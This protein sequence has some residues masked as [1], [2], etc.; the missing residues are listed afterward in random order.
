M[1]VILDARWMNVRGKH[2]GL[3]G[4]KADFEIVDKLLETGERSGEN[5]CSQGMRKSLSCDMPERK[6][7]I[8]RIE[9]AIQEYRRHRLS[10]FLLDFK[11][12][13]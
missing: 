2:G 13:S 12:D 7:S 11:L 9:Y 3:L 5:V 10:F 6:K 1:A 4:L 8:R